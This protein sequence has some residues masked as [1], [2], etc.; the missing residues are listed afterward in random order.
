MPHAF[1]QFEQR[2]EPFIARF[3][4]LTAPSVGGVSSPAWQ[5]PFSQQTPQS[6]LGIRF[7]LRSL[8]CHKGPRAGVDF[9]KWDDMLGRRDI[10]NDEIEAAAVAIHNHAP[11]IM[12]EP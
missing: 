2:F 7:F 4:G 6:F 8:S 1:I 11:P 5:M 9:I 3:Y 12:D 10:G